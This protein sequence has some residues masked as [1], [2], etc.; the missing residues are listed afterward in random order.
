MFYI[1]K[2]CALLQIKANF[3]SKLFAT[4]VVVLVPVPDTTAKAQILVTAG[5]AKYDATRKALVSGL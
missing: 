5:K 3:S 2:F 4:Q 1:R